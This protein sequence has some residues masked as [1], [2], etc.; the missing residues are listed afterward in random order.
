VIQ[1]PNLADNKIGFAVQFVSNCHSSSKREA[2]VRELRRFI[3][4]DIYG[5]C[6]E[7]KCPKEKGWQCYK[8]AESK[9]KFYLAFENS[10]CRDYV[11]EQFFN[12]YNLNMIPVVL[13]GANYS[14]IAPPHSFIN[15]ADFPNPKALAHYLKRLDA[16]DAKF[17]EYFWWRNFYA[18]KF[19]H[20]QAICDLC[21][22]LHTDKEH[23]TYD[24]M[25]D[26]WV[27]QAKCSS[28][29]II[30]QDDMI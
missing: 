9:Y 4:I 11:T 19:R 24:N 14:A 3:P 20:H 13:G 12:M 7:F 18:R 15:A 2:Y 10:V 5:K 8:K 17:N 26:W 27:N 22:R 6:G 25:Q 1:G 23:K 16:D 30:S 28:N 29:Y 21:Q